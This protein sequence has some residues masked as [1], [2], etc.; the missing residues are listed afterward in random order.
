MFCDNYQKYLNFRDEN[1]KN[2]SDEKEIKPD[3][4]FKVLLEKYL[5]Q[6]FIKNMTKPTTV[7]LLKATT[8]NSQLKNCIKGVYH[9]IQRCG[10][11]T[12][13]KKSCILLGCCWVRTFSPYINRC[14]YSKSLKLEEERYDLERSN[15]KGLYTC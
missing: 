15:S 2:E 7:P 9:P 5:E 11:K 8:S 12:E 14:V 6:K 4:M 10:L 13:N 1:A 3:S